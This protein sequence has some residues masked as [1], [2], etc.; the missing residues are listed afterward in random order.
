MLS[1]AVSRYQTLKCSGNTGV[2]EITFTPV[3]K[4]LVVIEGPRR[5]GAKLYQL[6]LQLLSKSVLWFVQ[7]KSSGRFVLKKYS[8]LIKAFSFYD[9]CF[10]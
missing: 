4:H 10:L 8:P 7:V 6:R 5:Q 2:T 1:V 9:F 3:P